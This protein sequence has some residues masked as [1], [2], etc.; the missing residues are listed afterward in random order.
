M[1][2]SAGLPVSHIGHE[3][4]GQYIVTGSPNV[5]V[6][7]T[8]VAWPISPR[9]PRPGAGRNRPQPWQPRPVP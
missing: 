3:V 2:A 4:A 9:S 6:G 8:A 5:F 1:A 7:S